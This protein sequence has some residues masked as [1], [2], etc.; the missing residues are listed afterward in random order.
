MKTKTSTLSLT[1]K[2][3]TVRVK[4]PTAI[5]PAD[6]QRA[7]DVAHALHEMKPKGPSIDVYMTWV[8]ICRRMADVFC[9]GDDSL[10]LPQFYAICEME[11]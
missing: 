11:L 8:D 6:V 2:R 5:L 3:A 10:P 7:I 4:K 9:W 1:K